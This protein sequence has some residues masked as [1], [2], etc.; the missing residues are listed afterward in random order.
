[1][2]KFE[3]TSRKE[4]LQRISNNEP[5]EGKWH[6]A[7]SKPTKV[8]PIFILDILSTFQ[9]FI[10]IQLS[11]KFFEGLAESLI[12]R[13]IKDNNLDRESHIYSQFLSEI[14]LYNCIQGAVLYKTILHD[15]LALT[16]G[17]YLGYFLT[18]PKKKEKES[19]YT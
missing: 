6:S 16:K 3:E 9:V 1:M 2:E 8:H 19:T 4:L 14:L 11:S 7:E 10:E 12:Y 15:L 17:M 5:I 18:V 13:A